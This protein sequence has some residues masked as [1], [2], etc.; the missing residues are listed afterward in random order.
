MSNID[1]N[2]I[3]DEIVVFLRNNITD[4]SSRMTNT[5]DEFDGNGS[6]KTFTLTKTGVKNVKTVTVGGA[7]QTFGTDYTVNY[8]TRVVTFT[9]APATGTDNVDINYDYGSPTWIYGDMP[10]TDIRLK[11]LPRIGVYMISGTTALIG[12]NADGFMTD[13]LV[14]ITAIATDDDTVKDLLNDVKNNIM[15]SKKSFYY[16]GLI[17]PVGWSPLT[18]FPGGNTEF[19]QQTLTC[20]IP[21]VFES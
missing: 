3:M 6:T 21:F 1:I 9:T 14:G 17:T 19:V 20:E 7:N 12:L 2:D 18:N 15:T 11:S 13:Y 4:P 16:F 5:T 10:R 8:S